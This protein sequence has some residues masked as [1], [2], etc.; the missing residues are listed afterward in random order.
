MFEK[1]I[2]FIRALYGDREFIPLHEPVLG[3]KEKAYLADC[4]DS[5]FV[6]SV[7]AYVERFEREI[8]RYTGATHAVATCNGTAAL[9]AALTAVGVDAECEVIT[10]PLTFV[11]TCNAIRYCGAEPAFVDIDPRTLGMCPASLERFFKE[12]T[13]EEAT[14]PVNTATGR[15]VA[16]VVPMHTFGHPCEIDTIAEICGRYGVPLVEDAAESLGSFYQ[17]RHTGTFGKAGVFSFNGNKILTTGGGGMIVTDDDALAARLRHLST[18]AKLPHPWRYEHD[19]VGFNYR[20]PNLNAALG[21]AQIE[22]LEELRNKKRKLAEI[23]KDFFGKIGIEFYSSPFGDASNHW[24][25]ALV[26]KGSEE[27]DRFLRLTNDHGVMTRPAWE[28]M[29][30]LSMY[31]ACFRTPLPATDEMAARLVN[32]PSSANFTEGLFA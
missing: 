16:A 6:S 25:N 30:R 1:A 18:T 17:N 9:H 2:D 14:G 13:R 8:A 19:E 15:R 31:A 28:P 23:Y 20:M 7:G 27:R 32:I 22:R 26:L 24:L 12:H 29:H 21:C 5:T 11:A 10:Q 4:I 3:E